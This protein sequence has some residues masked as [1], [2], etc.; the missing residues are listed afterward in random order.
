MRVFTTPAL[1]LTTPPMASD[2][3]KAF[4]VSIAVSTSG[5][6]VAFFVSTMVLSRVAVPYKSRSELVPSAVVNDHIS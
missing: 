1:A 5:K 6:T 4:L 3:I 2:S